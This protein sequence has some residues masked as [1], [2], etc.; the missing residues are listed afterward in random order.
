MSEATNIIE[1]ISMQL[2]SVFNE[3]IKNKYTIYGEEIKQGLEEPCF[4]IKLLTSNIRQIV[5]KRYFKSQLF[6]IHYF[7]KSKIE[8]GREML[9]IA[10]NLYEALEY[11]KYND[12]LFRGTNMNYQI[13]D[14]VLHFFVN[15][16]YYSIRE[17]QNDEYI[18]N[19]NYSQEVKK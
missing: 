13:I 6:D 19:L 11:I 12:E 3:E 10:D 7:P 5:G 16:N 18:T 8:S 4:F 9:D 14:D 1:A 15:Y 17:K 2:D